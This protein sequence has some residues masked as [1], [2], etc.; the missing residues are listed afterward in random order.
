[1]TRVIVMAW[2]DCT[3]VLIVVTPTNVV[4]TFT[5]NCSEIW[6]LQ[7]ECWGAVMV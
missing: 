7:V 5:A 2:H 3:N 1:M 6:S 4:G